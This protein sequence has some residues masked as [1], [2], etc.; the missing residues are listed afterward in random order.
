MGATFTSGWGGGDT[1]VRNSGGIAYI[2][3][4]SSAG[5]RDQY[6]AFYTTDK[7]G[8]TPTAQATIQTAGHMTLGFAA[9]SK[10]SLLSSGVIDLG[11]SGYGIYNNGSGYSGMG[12]GV[13][14][15]DTD[16]IYAVTGRKASAVE[17]SA[18]TV[19]VSTT[20]TTGTAGNVCTF[21]AGPYVAAGGTSWSTPSDERLKKNFS[22]APGLAAILKI[23]G[24]SFNYKTQADGETR[25][26]GFKAQQVQKVLPEAVNTSIK[27]SPDGD[28]YLG[29]LSDYLQ[30]S[31]VESIHELHALIVALQKQ[32]KALSAKVK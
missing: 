26:Y 20:N 5:A 16:W 6:L 7:S 18:G 14:S 25:H 4:P 27:I 19:Y 9:T 3:D 10:W 13:Y 32:V 30:A 11:E 24:Y 2:P 22:A 21:T 29:V 23:N 8:D 12:N 28:P 17:L 1:T 15:T 31:V